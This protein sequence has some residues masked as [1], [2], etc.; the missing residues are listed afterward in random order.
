MPDGVLAVAAVGSGDS[1][2]PRETD[3]RISSDGSSRQQVTLDFGLWSIAAGG[4]GLLATGLAPDDDE[5]GIWAS[6]DGT[7]WERWP[8]DRLPSLTTCDF[9]DPNCCCGLAVSS[10][11][12]GVTLV[13]RADDGQ[14]WWSVED[15]L[16]LVPGSLPELPS[17]GTGPI[18]TPI[19]PTADGWITANRNSFTSGTVWASTDGQTWVELSDLP[20]FPIV[21]TYPGDTLVAAGQGGWLA[22][23]DDD[24]GTWDVTRLTGAIAQDAVETADGSVLLTIVNTG[25]DPSTPYLYLRSDNGD[26]IETEV[27]A[28]PPLE[29]IATIEGTLIATGAAGGVWRWDRANT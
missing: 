6:T 11:A 13:G 25:P 20:G 10:N 3:L 26:W 9:E 1:G 29:S 17:S 15:D 14:K 23:S 19:T 18:V 16:A 8:D 28:V 4:P 12:D 27:T 7:D 21:F 24:G 22:V 5:P 2:P